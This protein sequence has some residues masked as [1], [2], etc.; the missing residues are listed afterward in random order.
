MRFILGR[1]NPPFSLRTYLHNTNAPSG[2]L[3]SLGVTSVKG[4]MKV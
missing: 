1:F 2:G 4:F 3:R